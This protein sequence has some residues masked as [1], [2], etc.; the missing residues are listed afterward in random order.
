[1]GRVNSGRFDR[2]LDDG[3]YRVAFLKEKQ[4]TFSGEWLG[5]LLFEKAD[6]GYSSLVLACSCLCPDRR[7]AS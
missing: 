4:T 7:T 6:H 2:K 5:Q 1:M 3:L